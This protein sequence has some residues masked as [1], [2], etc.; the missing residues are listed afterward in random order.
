MIVIMR[1]DVSMDSQYELPTNSMVDQS[2]DTDKTLK[3]NS[4]SSRDLIQQIL[5]FRDAQELEDIPPDASFSSLIN[6][7]DLDFQTAGARELQDIYSVFRE[8]DCW[9]LVANSLPRLRDR[10]INSQLT[11]TD[12]SSSSEAHMIGELTRNTLWLLTHAN[13]LIPSDEITKF[14]ELINHP[15]KRVRFHSTQ[16]VANLGFLNLNNQKISQVIKQIQSDIQPMLDQKKVNV[17]NIS[18]FPDPL[19]V[20]G[21][22]NL[23]RRTISNFIS[24]EYPS[25]YQG[26]ANLQI[27]ERIRHDIVEKITRP[28]NNYD[29][30]TARLLIDTVWADMGG[31]ADL[32]IRTMEATSDST[33]M[34]IAYTLFANRLNAEEAR[35]LLREHVKK[36]PKFMHK[37]TEIE[38][39]IGFHPTY[40]N[41]AD[42][43]TESGFK[44]DYGPNEQLT[45]IEIPLLESYLKKDYISIDFG[46]G[47][48][49]HLIPLTEK[50]YKIIGIDITPS[51]FN[52]VKNINPQAHLIE[53][54]FHNVALPDNSTNV[55]YMLGRT[56]LQNATIGEW[57]QTIS[58]AFRLL[59]K[60]TTIVKPSQKEEA[61]SLVDYLENKNVLVPDKEIIV[62]P[63]A[64]KFILDKPKVTPGDHYEQSQDEYVKA[65]DTLGVAY[66]ERGGIIDSP[67]GISFSDRFNPSEKQLKAIAR[68]YGFHAK[69]IK[70]AEYTDEEGNKNT[71]EYWELSIV[72]NPPTTGEKLALSNISRT[73]GPPLYFEWI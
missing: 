27:F 3:E 6:I 20:R 28:T 53:S 2:A 60:P 1:Y 70:I 14:Y 56:S 65:Q 44:P 4:L 16:Y 73:S 61:D 36:N 35:K 29:R 8:L 30:H 7:E 58:E 55:I 59:R 11:V 38:K 23:R 10:F 25:D 54:S 5:D 26:E 9:D 72:N 39:A 12:F 64:S 34:Q 40:A 47:F 51:Y 50:G 57:E 46:F 17:N 31:L 69:I 41:V 63:R 67:D 62:D 37:R 71:N 68:Y 32:F 22:A 45:E 52:Y 43:Y 24:G 66:H 15:D 13:T 49:R 19:D 18:G 21:E 48:G 42:F 33:S